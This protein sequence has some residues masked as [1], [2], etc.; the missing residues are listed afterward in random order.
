MF[1]K[2]GRIPHLLFGD[3]LLTEV[4]LVRL[5]YRIRNQN[6]VNRIVFVVKLRHLR[7]VR[8]ILIFLDALYYTS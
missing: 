2:D 1:L 6:G 5:W 4:F 8:A 3:L 7:V